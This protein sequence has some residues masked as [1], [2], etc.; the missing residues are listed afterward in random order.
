MSRKNG[1]T[2]VE[3]L[4][5]I[6]I[7]GMSAT[8]ATPAFINLNRTR[9]VRA[10]SSELRSIFQLTRGRAI[11]TGRNAG[12]KF[13]K[14][15]SDW[16][17]SLYDDGDGDG[18]RNDDI[19]SGVDPLRRSAARVVLNARQAS[20]AVPPLKI[21]DPDGDALTSASSPVQFNSSTLCSFSPVGEA[22]P[23][24]IYVSDRVGDV[25]AVRVY[26]GSGRVRVLRYNAGTK[27]WDLR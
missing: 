3:L 8:I 14:S 15:G 17:Y 23:G 25:W 2:A 19:K 6:A 5:V 12:V 24:T 4:A 9:A 10:A 20:I 22:T 21:K 27:K 26:G 7:I 1:F 18:V 11:A 13:T 16:Y